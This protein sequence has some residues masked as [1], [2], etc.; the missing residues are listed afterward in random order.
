[1]AKTVF[2]GILRECE[3]SPN[4][5]NDDAAI[6]R[7]TGRV[8]QELTG[9]E[10]LIY[11]PEE[12][13]ESAE[14]PDLIFFMCERPE[15]LDRLEAMQKRGVEMVN[16]P[17]S[18]RETYRYNTVKKLES[19]EFYPRTAMLHTNDG[20]FGEFFPLW[21]KRF[22][23]HAVTSEDV[24]QVKDAGDLKAKLAR[25]KARGI[26][27]VLAQQHV[28]GDL[29]KFYGIHDR[30]FEHFYHKDQVLKSYPFE[31]SRLKEIARRGAR[32]LGVEIFGGDAIVTK[33]GDIY[34]IDLNAWP[35][36]AL[37]RKTASQHIA[38]HIVD[39]IRKRVS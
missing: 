12:I 34:L 22:D 25:F 38:E 6:L 31:L 7:E 11:Q 15:V 24:C 36:F 30:W 37:Y 19:F 29:I 23:F 35:S 1:M 14:L 13:P 10:V 9:D 26:G 28:E 18:V 3:H 17:Q 39:K 16:T 33:S 20:S 2:W 8:I 27:Q 5:E 21:L 32:E 4:R